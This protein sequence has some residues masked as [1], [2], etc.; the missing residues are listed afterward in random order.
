M[1]NF[2]LPD[3]PN[4]WQGMSQDQINWFKQETKELL[5]I[6]ARPNT[7]LGLERDQKLSIMGYSEDEIERMTGF[8]RG[9]FPF[10][11]PEST[12]E[13]RIRSLGK[14]I[15]DKLEALEIRCRAEW[16][17]EY[18]RLVRYGIARGFVEE[19]GREPKL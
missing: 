3:N 19:E 12:K 2:E 7:L 1:N 9:E 15:Y 16:E 5:K 18:D 10:L 14:E 8:K 6:K 4:M 13:D 17:A 11:Y